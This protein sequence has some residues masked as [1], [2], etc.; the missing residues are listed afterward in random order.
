MWKRLA[1]VGK[2]KI[3]ALYNWSMHHNF[4]IAQHLFERC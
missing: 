1:N 3:A 4:S 2:A